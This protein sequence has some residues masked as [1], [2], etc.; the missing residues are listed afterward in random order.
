MPKQYKILQRCT[1]NHYPYKLGEVY[2]LDD[3]T[4]KA[5]GPYAEF[6]GEIKDKQVK[7]A[8]VKKGRKNAEEEEE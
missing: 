2:D 7:T 6:V 1:V 3:E 4:A 8:K 5:L